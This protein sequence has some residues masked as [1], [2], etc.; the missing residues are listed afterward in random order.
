MNALYYKY[1]T[2][3]LP[4]REAYETRFNLFTNLTKLFKRKKRRTTSS[5]SKSNGMINFFPLFF[6]KRI[7]NET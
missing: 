3:S 7:K 4:I 5:Q 2:Y 6:Q 1:I